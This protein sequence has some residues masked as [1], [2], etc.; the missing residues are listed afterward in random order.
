MIDETK[1]LNLKNVLKNNCIFLNY[2]N[3]DHI[4]ENFHEILKAID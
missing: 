4:L 3:S 1:E 2:E